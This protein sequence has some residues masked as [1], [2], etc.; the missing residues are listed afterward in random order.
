MNA[1][2]L[3][4]LR[5]PVELDDF[6][7]VKHYEDNKYHDGERK[8]HNTIFEHLRAG[9][10]YELQ[11]KL[12]ISRCY[13]HLLTVS[14]MNPVFDNVQYKEDIGDTDDLFLQDI[15]RQN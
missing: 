3:I 7:S 15:E 14:C 4:E 8:I 12:E 9:K 13:D 2:H 5:A 6:D 10:L 1:S 11:K